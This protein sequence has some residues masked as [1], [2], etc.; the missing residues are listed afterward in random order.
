[1][2]VDFMLRRCA[3]LD[4]PCPELN[5]K[6][7]EQFVAVPGFWD[8]GKTASDAPFEFAGES[9]SLDLRTV[10]ASGLGGQV[11]YA[12]RFAGYLSRDIAQSGDFIWLRLDTEKADY[13]RFCSATLPQLIDI[14]KP[15]RAAA[16][17][18]DAV[19][20]ADFDLVCAQSQKSGRDIDGRDSVHRIW[21]VCFFDDLLCRRAF[22]ISAAEVAARAAPECER[23]EVMHGGAFLLVTSEIIVGP[24]LD[25]L[26]A[27]VMARLGNSRA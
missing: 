20:L 7:I 6:F 21:P 10:L 9:A 24:A 8:A 22:G 12:P 4:E 23:A 18:D 3:S 2:N 1:M 26:N 27:R 5:T 16:H 14:F 17:T 11:S 19:M 15:Y 25:A 13:A